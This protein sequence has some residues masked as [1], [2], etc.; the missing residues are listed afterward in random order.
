MPKH[1]D[2]QKIYNRFVKQYGQA[3]G[4]SLYFAFIKKKGYD[5][6]KPLPKKKERKEKHCIVHGVEV[7]EINGEF[8]VRGLVATSHIDNVDL[9][10][11]V[12][13]PDMIPKET[14]ES[15]AIQINTQSHSRV[16]GVHHSEAFGIK[17]G[18][19]DVS[20]TPAI[21]IP[22]EDGEW[23]LY[24]DTKI[25]SQDP[26]SQSIIEQWV[27]GQ[28][29]SFSITYETEGF[30]TTDFSWIDDRIVRVLE[31]DTKLFGYT[32]ASNPK[33]PNA[34]AMDYG[35]KEF[36]ELVKT[37]NKEG[38]IMAKEEKEVN[39]AAPAGE[40]SAQPEENKTAE[41]KPA[42]EKKEESTEKVETKVDEKPVDEEKKEFEKFKAEKA[43]KEFKE[44]VS[45]IVAEQVNTME[46]KEK[47]L[48]KEEQET[49]DLPLET[50]EFVE[51]F[52]KKKDIELKEQFRRAGVLADKLGL[53][54]KTTSRADSREYK[55][56]ATN[57][58][59]LEFKSLGITTN[60]TTYTQSAAE[61][62]DV[63]DPVIYNALN[64]ETVTWNLLSK[65]DYSMKGNNMCQFTLKTAA[66][67]SAAFYTG[68]SVTTGNVTRTKFQT[69]FK[70]L[71]VGIQV[72]GDMIA[73]AKGG[74]VGDIF[75]QEVMDSAMDMLAVLNAALFGV[76]GAETDAG[77][78]G[79][80][81]IANSATYTT[82]Y[83]LT[84]S[85][86]N[87]LAP[88]S[89]TDTFI[90]GSSVAVAVGNLRKAIRQATKE[91]ERKADL[92]FICDPTQADMLRSKFD[93]S[94]R[95][96][97]PTDTGFG[98]STDLFVDGVPVFEDKDC[99][100]DD[101]FLISRATHRVGIWQPPT[102]EML[103]KAGDYEGGFIKMYLATY[104]RRP[105]A[106]VQIYGNATS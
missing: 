64:Q 58:R 80:E 106:L 104:N 83:G 70:K 74:P 61:L 45:K 79:F 34:V 39:Q 75:A 32:A 11:G 69:K 63:Y 85:T 1:A 27:D 10:D 43:D 6:T 59:F 102:I 98:F 88:D 78:I 24:V 5:D 65:D 82:L 87:K 76:T 71:Q 31:P 14:L 40:T 28:L 51:I 93:D 21:V 72:D 94:R 77:I 18:E 67:A 50:K 9:E 8:H 30:Q 92:M 33:N 57:G 103:G 19:A 15:M 23:G 20:V 54:N 38:A 46:V 100:D 13:I 60:S 81:Y 73:A 90:N 89:A 86:A 68:N 25:N 49:N 29:N 44:K 101:W 16:M 42:E 37:Q 55:S 99:N 26:N 96:A 91:G 47:V 4:E 36:K 12:E 2:F 53:H 3:K 41:E 17:H 35:F 84:R 95:M 22:L 48:N 97:Q 7:K 62:Q 105:R 66:N 52:D 56:F